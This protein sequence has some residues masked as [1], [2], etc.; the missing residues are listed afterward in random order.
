MKRLVTLTMLLAMILGCLGAAQAAT[1][2]KMSGDYRVHAN[3]WSQYQFTNWN[4]NGTQAAEAFNVWERFRVRTDFVA[5]ESLKFRL[6][7]KIADL[8]WGNNTFTVDNPAVSILVYQAYLQFKWPN[9]QIRFTLGM[10]GMDLPLSAGWLDANP[11]LGG[12]HAAAGIVEIPVAGEAFGVQLGYVRPMDSN[13]QFDPTT[14]QK[15]DELDLFFLT[16]PIALDGFKAT[17]WAMIGNAG[18]DGKYTSVYVGNGGYTNE[19]LSTNLFSASK[20]SGLSSL[21]NAQNLYW[22]AGT[23]LSITAADPFKFY[24]DI[25]YGTGNESDRKANRRGGLFFDVAAEYTGF[26]MFTPQLTF[27]YSTGED[28]STSNGSERMPVIVNYWGPSNSFLFYGDQQYNNGNMAVN[29][30]G[31]M[32]VAASL[33]DISF[34]KDLTHRLTVSYA[35]GTNTPKGLRMANAINGVGNYVQIGRDLTTQESIWAVNFDHQYN[36]YENLAAIVETGWA[37]GDFQTSVWG[38]RFTNQTRNGDAWK[39][40]FGFKYKF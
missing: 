18:R 17:P 13:P 12:T 22:W 32:G 37:H 36:I 35:R 28:G 10:Q 3:V 14:T 24:G 21:K 27:W 30:V 31:S 8:V 25:I 9:T 11:V 34:V 1:E 15:A 38:H 33:N 19:T 2:V 20:V 7:I 16:L 39:V 40:S 5:N 29:A 26:N 23:T 6:G 4:Y